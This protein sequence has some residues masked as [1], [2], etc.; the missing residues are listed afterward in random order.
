MIKRSLVSISLVFKDNARSPTQTSDVTQD[1]EKLIQLLFVLLQGDIALVVIARDLSPIDPRYV[2]IVSPSRFVIASL[3]MEQ[4]EAPSPR[5]RFLDATR[6]SLKRPYYR[7]ISILIDRVYL[8]FVQCNV[9]PA[10]SPGKRIV[11]AKEA[12]SCPPLTDEALSCSTSKRRGCLS[13]RDGDAIA[14]SVSNYPISR[15][16]FLISFVRPFSVRRAF[17]RRRTQFTGEFIKFAP[18]SRLIWHD[19]L[20]GSRDK[21]S[22]PCSRLSLRPLPP[23]SLERRSLQ[24]ARKA[25]ESITGIPRL[26]QR[27][28][29]IWQTSW[30]E[31]EHVFNRFTKDRRKLYFALFTRSLAIP[32]LASVDNGT[33]SALPVPAGAHKSSMRSNR[34][35]TRK[36]PSPEYR[37]AFAASR[38]S[39][40]QCA[41]DNVRERLLLPAKKNGD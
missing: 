25:R 30:N 23:L 33:I 15:R 4:S 19:R 40:I 6:S 38:R 1:F 11:R 3:R 18:S 22:P 21:L 10:Y 16:D 28:T 9:D 41:H 37:D 29:H 2:L 17:F 27:E 13:V 34:K 24:F 31:N 5:V 36:W 39:A 35:S 32:M 7:I 14:T 26:F 8:V 20:I 12:A